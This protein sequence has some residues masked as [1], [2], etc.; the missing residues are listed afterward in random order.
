MSTDIES[1]RLVLRL[2]T[3]P[4]IDAV[5]AGDGDEAERVLGARTPPEWPSED[6]RWLLSFRRKQMTQSNAEWLLRAMIRKSDNAFIGHIGFHGE[7]EDGIAEAGY[8]VSA[9]HRRQGYAEEAVRALFDWARREHGIRR[10]RASIGPW[11]EPSLALI[12]KLGFVQT[13]TQWD[14]RDGE[15][16]VFEL[17]RGDPEATQPDEDP[18]TTR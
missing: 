1:P 3:R 7:P 2:M 4:F 13:G 8:E 17:D 15:E 18:T 5:L 14:E 11:N 16:S 12:R 6:D 9:A 10:F